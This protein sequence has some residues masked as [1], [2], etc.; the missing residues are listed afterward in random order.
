MSEKNLLDLLKAY[1]ENSVRLEGQLRSY[2]NR[3]QARVLVA[4]CF[5]GVGALICI[6]LLF[7]LTERTPIQSEFIRFLLSFG[8]YALIGF[9]VFFTLRSFTSPP[10][11][12]EIAVEIEQ[13]IGKFHS[14]LS[15]AADFAGDDEAPKGSS[16][17][18]RKL[19]VSGAAEAFSE[20]D[21]RLALKKF[22]RKKAFVFFLWSFVFLAAWFSIA[23]GEVKRGFDRLA[24]PF[25]DIAAFSPLSIGVH[26]GNRIVPRGQTVQIIAIPN[27]PVDFAPV[28]TLF[29]SGMTEGTAVEMFPD[30]A[31]SRTRYVSVLESLQDSADYQVTCEKFTSDR[32]SLTVMPR[33]EIKSLNL[34]IHHP[35]YLATQPQTLP[36]GTGDC[37]VVTGTRVEIQGQ[38]SQFL[39]SA[40]IVKDPGATTPLELIHR[41]EFKHSFSVAT[42][43]RYSFFL[44]NEAGLENE[45][46]VKY[47]ITAKIDAPPTITILKPGTDMPFP[48]SKRLD[49]KVEARDDFG[50]VSVVLFY[51]LGDRRHFIPLNMKADFSPMREFEVEYPWLLDTLA[52][53][54]G[55][56]IEYYAQAEDGV[57]PVPNVASTPI[58]NVIMPSEY[59]VNRGTQEAQGEVTTKLQEYLEN[60]KVRRESLEKA[61]QEIK[62]EGKLDEETERQIQ[63][64]IQEGEQRE[65]DAQEILDKIQKVND[66]LKDNPL[67]SPETIEKMQKIQDL[68]NEVLDD[69]A[70]KLMKQLRE[71][72]KDVKLDPKD[73]EK[74]EDAFKMENY[75]KSLDRTVELLSQ[76]KEQMKMDNL[77]KAVEELLKRQESISSETKGLEEK[78]KSGPLSPE[79]ESKLKDLA[80][81]QEK[82]KEELDQLQK[83]AQELA[84]KK[85][86]EGSPPNPGSEDV[87][88]LRDKMKQE[89]FKKTSEEIKKELEKK[90]LDQAQQLQQKMLKFLDALNQDGK[91][92][93]TSCGGGAPPQ[94]DLSR[95]IR[96]A[97]G[98]SRDQEKLLLQIEGLPGKFMRGERPA[99]EGIIDES[100]Y[101]EL[102]VKKQAQSLE[103][104]LETFVRS[105]MTID[106][107]ILVPLKGVQGM[108]TDIVK[109]LEDRALSRARGQQR[110]IILRFNELAMELMR[111]QDQNSSQSQ[112]NNPMDALKQFKDLTRRQLSLYQQQM[113][114]QMSPSDQKL[115]EDL[116]KMAMEQ[117]MI[118]E[119]LE[120]IMREAR[121]QNQ[122]LGRMD[123]VL[124]D[125]EDLETKI[126]D[127][128][129]RKEVA[130]KQKSI[131]DRMLKAQKSI[132]NRDE[133]KEERKAEKARELIQTKVEKP[134]PTLGS[135]TRDLSRDFLGD[136]KEDYPKSYETMLQ[137][138]YKS[139]SLYGE[140]SD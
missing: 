4:R 137:D 57:R 27:Q 130:E 93:C 13:A 85:P 121:K 2:R 135:D 80:Q 83:E 9:W 59:D 12:I 82:I 115:M 76:F 120:Q 53:M 36:D 112:S 44:K 74:Y 15:S 24:H 71:S 128:S 58:F 114:K 94:M 103:D 69:E 132:R 96:K 65:K 127:P 50:V 30:E 119:A 95:F 5:A 35:S 78:Q 111:T 131:Y 34:T 100:S 97:I 56:K 51:S 41:E 77:G 45:N 108:F 139:L 55:T 46:P 92:I 18:L 123:D 17:A 126:L 129:K 39:E 68:L 98:V 61:Y 72:L 33:P 31:A 86:P 122:M 138:Y 32:F 49:L 19:T 63:K 14:A 42:T 113:Q 20:E 90:N 25:S 16:P 101:L 8:G 66:S 28:L 134:L 67:S 62:H 102:V 88:N 106:P 60:Q 109:D 118:R 84:E 79:D 10:P 3:R 1:P 7:L 89:D 40:A 104:S 21:C 29:K 124:K 91:K 38:A 75:I 23:P 140:K 22:S 6:L 26:P 99:I 37:T 87:K 117:K 107:R 54:P 125:M 105:N 81:Q 11:N 52:V 136:L 43:T 70:K 133:E 116:K 47:Q 110:M 64:A 73:L 48:K